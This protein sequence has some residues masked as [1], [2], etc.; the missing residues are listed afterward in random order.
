MP[1]R[2]RVWELRAPWG[3]EQML[4]TAEVVNVWCWGAGGG[5]AWLSLHAHACASS[6]ISL[7]Y[8]TQSTPKGFPPESFLAWEEQA[9]ILIVRVTPWEIGM[10]WKPL[11][12]G[13]EAVLVQHCFSLLPVCCGGLLVGL[14]PGAEKRRTWT[15]QMKQCSL[16]LLSYSPPSQCQ[17]VERE[18][19]TL[20]RGSLVL[21]RRK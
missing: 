2:R 6:H 13:D 1:T 10:C 12:C 15:A 14:R 3:A 5:W 17:D 4:S 18:Q 19:L 8:L 7:C 21:Y 9:G 20:T 11:G 16:Y